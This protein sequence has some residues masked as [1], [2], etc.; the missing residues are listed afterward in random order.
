MAKDTSDKNANNAGDKANRE[1]ELEQKLTEA[2]KLTLNK[3]NLL[4][5]LLAKNGVRDVL[6]AEQEGRSVTIIDQDELAS[7]KAGKEKTAEETV[8]APSIDDSMS[9]Q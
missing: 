7:L 5:Q 9:N 1:N 6:K 2:E 4:T 8:T 3:E